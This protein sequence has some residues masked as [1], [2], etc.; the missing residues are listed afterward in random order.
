MARGE[1]ISGRSEP[2][3][4]AFGEVQQACEQTSAALQLVVSEVER[5]ANA[6]SQGDFSRRV[7]LAS[8]RGYQADLGARLNALVDVTAS[9][10]AEVSR[11]LGAIAEGDLT[12]RINRQFPGTFGVLGEYCNRT[13]DAVGLTV[14]RIDHVLQGAVEGDFSRNVD[15]TGLKGYQVSLATKVNGS[16]RDVQTNM[17][18]LRDIMSALARGE[19][20]AHAD[21]SARGV[22]G[23]I[24]GVVNG[25]LT[26]LRDVIERVQQVSESVEMASSEVNAGNRSLNDRTQEQ[27]GAVDETAQLSVTMEKAVKD[28]I[29]R[30]QEARRFIEAAE[31]QAQ[32]VGRVV[33]QAMEAMREIDTNSKKIGSIIGLI[34][35]IAFQTNLLALNAAVE[36]ARAG[37]QGRGF[38]VVAAEVRSLAQRSA[39]AAK[40]IT[41]Q[42]KESIQ[43]VE[44][45]LALVDK[46]GQAVY[47]IVNSVKEMN[48]IIAEVA[49][50][51]NE[52]TGSLD[53]VRVAVSQLETSVQQN[54]ALVEELSAS[55][56][57]LN[58]QSRQLNQ[59]I[60]FFKV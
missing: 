19:L 29:I 9:G 13:V 17:V 59:V 32:G 16:M 49:K 31:E 14:Q 18:Q 28:N 53:Q 6:A 47:E 48:G 33:T 55:T 8:L 4:G 3:P 12:Q 36:A 57:S 45:G 38:A 51:G 60:G 39:A 1:R 56:E 11:V 24:A 26:T 23:E 37:E 20:S 7:E 41:G 40:E 50:S 58:D 46:S 52:Q 2:L 27:S 34:D 42:V 21:A 43:R 5:V 25:T 15:N 44:D 54:A 10:L 22:F 30:T 35:E